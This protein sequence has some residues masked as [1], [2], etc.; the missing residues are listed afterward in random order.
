VILRN[1]DDPA[2]LRRIGQID[3]AADHAATLTGQLLAFS[4]QQCSSLSRPT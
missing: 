1:T 4:R 3:L 2:L